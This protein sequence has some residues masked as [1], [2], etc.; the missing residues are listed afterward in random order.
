MHPIIHLGYALEYNQPSLVAEALAAACVHD[1]WPKDFILPT[2]D[3]LRSNSDVPSK[4]LLQVLNDLRQDPE[5]SSAV[6]DT[7]PFNK[8]RDGFHKRVTGEQIAPYLSQFQVRPD[9]KELQSKM[10]EMMY[11]CAYI[12]GAAQ[13]PGKRERMDFVLVHNVTLSVFYPAILALDWMTNQEKARF[14]EA[15][16]RIDAVMYGACKCPELYPA[17]IVD[18]LPRHPGHGWTELFHRSNIYYDEGHAVKLIRALFSLEQLGD[19]APGFPL[20]KS[21]FVK[22]AHMAMDSIESAL[23]KNGHKMPEKLTESVTKNVGQGGEMVASNMMRWVFYGGLS[24]AWNFVPDLQT[25][26]P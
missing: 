23:E 2:E 25:S 14:I 13:R 1:D 17:R 6:R 22:I 19:T 12:M 21:E 20:K 4:P 5:I 18:Y 11:T 7:D 15:K 26:A 3:Y 10:E 16:A 24:N 9:P 8:I